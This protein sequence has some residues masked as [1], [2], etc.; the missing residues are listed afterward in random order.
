MIKRVLHLLEPKE[1]KDGIKVIGSIFIVTLLD[2]V[3]LASLLP[4]LYYLLEG[5]ANKEAALYFA[6]LSTSVI[7]FKSAVSIFLSRFQSRYLLGIYKRLSFSLYSNYYRNG[8]LFIREKGYSTL[9]HSVNFMCFTFSE[10]IL[11]PLMMMAGEILLITLVTAA[12]LIYDWRTIVVLYLCFMPFMLL[13]VTLVRKK[14]KA[15]GEQEFKAK[16]KQAKI[17]TDTFRGYAELEINNAFP[18]LQQ[19]FLSGVDQ[20]SKNRTK[21]LTIQMFP[22]FIS[23][24][25][26]IIGMVIMV[27]MGGENARMLVG[28]F[29]VSAFRLLPALRGLLSGF[30]QLQNALPSLEILEEGIGNNDLSDNIIKESEHFD[31]VLQGNSIEID[32]VKF[33]YGDSM[34]AFGSHKINKGEYVGLCG[35]S[36]VG[37]TTL[38]N[39]IL[40]FLQ[41][42]EGQV[43]I[44]GVQLTPENRKSWLKL[45]GYVPQE[46]FIFNGTIA[47]NIALGYNDIDE[48]KVFKVLKMVSLGS[49]VSN[50]EKGIHNHLGE[51]GGKLS[52]GQKQRIGIARALYKDASVLLL[53]E[54]TSALDNNTEK[55]INDMLFELKKEI[56]ALTILSIAHRESTLSFC[57]RIINLGNN[58]N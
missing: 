23:E 10:R 13:Y 9:G 14:V 25:A 42:Q 51:G 38:F 53:D 41:P 33:S 40:G 55:E 58:G 50:L 4:I 54:A 1:R 48:E 52:G 31:V 7:L 18:M 30:T 15:Y 36:G 35:Y 45:I 21:M 11:Y 37:K 6:L 56:P 17:V 5:G 47:E 32:D 16:R 12:L 20:V 46:V 27:I 2:F 8:L 57:N 3:G 26:V 28:I 24:L 44:D 22:K 43:L 49:W 29:A 39:L 19:S 34:L